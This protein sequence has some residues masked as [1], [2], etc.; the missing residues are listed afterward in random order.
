MDGDGG[1]SASSE[2]WALVGQERL[3]VCLAMSASVGRTVAGTSRQR[4]ELV[5]AAIARAVGDVLPV[6]EHE[7]A[8]LVLALCDDRVRD[9]CMVQ[10]DL[11][12]T[13]A[14]QRLWTALVVGTPQPYRALPASMLTCTAY[15]LGDAQ[16][17]RDSI[18]YALDV[19]PEDR[20]V[21]SSAPE[22]LVMPPD[23]LRRAAEQTA[24]FARAHI[25]QGSTG[26]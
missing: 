4:L 1:S 2:A 16:L 9:A 23:A 12:H 7:M 13:L 18:G 22:G 5:D 17:A 19:D 20:L 15:L 25:Q 21:L 14:A 10:A 6:R 11:A 3:A 26:A 8:A 24:A